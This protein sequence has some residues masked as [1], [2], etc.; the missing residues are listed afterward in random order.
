VRTYRVGLIGAGFM[1]RTHAWC[2]RSLPFFYD[3]L[4]YRCEL[5]GITTSRPETAEAARDAWSVT[6]TYPDAEAMIA[7]P[8]IDLIDIATPNHLHRDALLLANAHGKTVYCEKPLTGNPTQAL[9]VA[10]AVPDLDRAGQVVFHN[11]FL[12]ATMRAKAMMEA[13][14]VGDVICFR[15]EYLHSGN[16]A[17]GKRMVWKDRR[18]LG[19]GVLYDL[20]SHAVDVVT[21]LCGQ[22]IVEVFARQKTLHCERPSSEDPSIL[23][24]QEGDDATLMSVVLEGGAMGTIEANKIATGKQ[25]ELRFEI[26]GTHGA[27]RFNLMDPNYLDWFDQSDPETPLGGTSGFKRIHCVQRYGA[28]AGF[29]TPKA[30]IGWLRAHMHSLYSYISRVHSAEPFD[31]SLARGVAVERMLDAAQRSADSGIEVSLRKGEAPP[32]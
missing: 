6:K 28:P 7:D 2:W 31:P 12:P 32:A 1:G 9:E 21:W 13:G 23:V 16:V 26:H 14:E 3:G 15:A 11:R 22:E 10:S 25:D 24:R 18:E 29:P 30:S 20:G 17:A 27:L 4:D 19:A 8:G 5:A